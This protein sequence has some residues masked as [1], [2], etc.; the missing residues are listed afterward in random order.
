MTMRKKGKILIPFVGKIVLLI[1]E[2]IYL[3]IVVHKVI[4]SVGNIRNYKYI[5]IN[6]NELYN[7][8]LKEIRNTD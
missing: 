3:I 7:R 8:R 6:R 1:R 4:L 5:L 2:I